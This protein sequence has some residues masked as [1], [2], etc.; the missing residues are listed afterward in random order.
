MQKCKRHL[1]LF[2]A[3]A[4]TSVMGAAQ[5]A[6]VVTETEVG[7][8]ASGAVASGSL[9]V[10]GDGDPTRYTGDRVHAKLFYDWDWDHQD[11]DKDFAGFRPYDYHVYTATPTGTD[12]EGNLNYTQGERITDAERN[13]DASKERHV[14]FDV[15]S[16]GK[17]VGLYAGE[18]GYWE[19]GYPFD[20]IAAK[21]ITHLF[22]SFYGVCDYNRDGATGNRGLDTMNGETDSHAFQTMRA[23]CG[24]GEAPS[25]D[26][27][28]S[29]DLV[30]LG[31]V[32]RKQDFEISKYDYL[33]EPH[34]ID[35]MRE[36]KARYPHLNAMLSIG[37]WSLSDPFYD[38]VSDPQW[39][40][41]FIDSVVETVRA[42][43][44]L[45][46]GV[47][48]DWEF[49]GGAGLSSGLTRG[50]AADRDN[51]V[52]LVEEL[53]A[54]LTEEFGEDFQ[55]SAAISTDPAKIAAIDLSR[56]KDD[57]TFVNVMTYDL[58]GAWGADPGHQ[59]G[60]R[61]KP[62]MGAYD[63]APADEY[64]TDEIGN[65]VEVDGERINKRE[66]VEGFSV[67]GAIK[68]IQR[69]YPDFPMSK[70]AVGAASYSRGWEY[71]KVDDAHDKMPWH[72]T[73]Q[74]WGA[75][76][77]DTKLGIQGTFEP[78]VAD[79]RDV[80]DNFI[81]PN[82][83]DWLYYDRQADAAYVW[84]PR[85]DHSGDGNK[86]ATVHSMDTPRSVIA[87][88]DLVQEYDL[89]GLFVWE[90]QTDNGMILNAVNAAVCNQL[91]GGGY[92]DFTQHYAGAVDTEVLATDANGY[93]TQVRETVYGPH[94]YQFLGASHC[95]GTEPGNRAPLAD[96]GS[97]VSV[98]GPAIVDLDASGSSDPDGDT[99]TYS[100]TQEAGPSAT[101]SGADTAMPSVEVPE[102]QAETDFIFR[103]S[104]GDGK[105][106][107]SDRVTVTV[108]T[109][110]G[111]DGG[112]NC[113]ATWSADVAYSGGD[114]V[115]YQGTEYRAK[116]WTKG[117]EPGSGNVWEVV[118][119]STCSDD[120]SG[121]GDTGGGDS[122]DGDGASCEAWDSTIAY[123]AGDVV[124]YEGTEYRAKWWTKGE[125]PGSGQN[126]P[127]EAL[128]SADCG[129]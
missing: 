39:R 99:L 41:T 2:V 129:A 62:V 102:V 11:P 92:Y 21:N 7:Q 110:G 52:K 1:A 108:T 33:A 98:E 85:P 37:G 9:S 116:W 54:R 66:K 30:D 20:L 82:G 14:P 117:D 107:D 38:M 6:D 68:T 4:M 51:F 50:Y 97:K 58:F 18:W 94:D 64:A 83:G 45:W 79:Y 63:E 90:A 15:T 31:V 32:E 84:K 60:V 118:S 86:V 100:W 10:Q 44:G 105:Q 77:G 76:G 48:L 87:K 19:R 104:V 40:S 35:A 23:S 56:L 53:R 120:G 57:F 61:A 67:E 122:G 72:G 114:T 43:D 128:G 91:D 93:A 22:F 12:W 8:D 13:W 3:G 65:T 24:Q 95:S 69:F 80:Y 123:T 112:G 119:D 74:E 103:V 121:G 17:I 88:G 113:P 16:S 106:S 70:L 5:A 36:M 26:G 127:W 73:A 124:V 125:T 101:L 29:A 55:L 27:S 47:D 34:A 78:G 42:S 111:G 89:A 71:V 25:F 126:G 109:P 81:A 96:A 75:Y 46:D 49:P 115:M 28:R 59:T